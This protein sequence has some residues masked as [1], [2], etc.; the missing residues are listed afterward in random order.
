[1]AKQPP[2]NIKAFSFLDLDPQ[3]VASQLFRAG[4]SRRRVDI[5]RETITDWAKSVH[6]AFCAAEE[7]NRGDE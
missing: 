2:D 6:D 3:A 7:A 1:M 4:W 5:L